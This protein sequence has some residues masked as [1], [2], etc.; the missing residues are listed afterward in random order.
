VHPPDF[1]S[2]DHLSLCLRYGRPDGSEFRLDFD[3]TSL[4]R[5][6][7]TVTLSAGAGAVRLMRSELVHLARIIPT[8][9]ALDRPHSDIVGA[10]HLDLLTVEAFDE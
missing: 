4:A 9:A 6:D 8:L 7:W 2:G 5:E 1:W 3:G 10:V